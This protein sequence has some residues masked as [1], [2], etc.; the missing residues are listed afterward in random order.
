ML[1]RK[2]IVGAMIAAGTLGAVALPLPSLAATRVMVVDR[3][4][5][6]SREER[7]PEH[8]RGYV[9]APGF[10]DW[11]HQ[12][13]VWVK[14]H[15]VRERKGYAYVEPRWAERNGHW[16]LSRSRWDRD[17]DGVPN[18]RDAHPDNPRRG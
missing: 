8:R 9:W 7:V 4:P 10:W 13:H 16:E 6:P 1:A 18:N 17:G 5:P 2:I 14:G 12:K 15:W 11:K 3:A